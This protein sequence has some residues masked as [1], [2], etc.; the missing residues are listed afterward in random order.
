[1]KKRLLW[2]NEC[3]KRTLQKRVVLREPVDI[4]PSG[5]PAPPKKEEVEEEETL[6]TEYRCPVCGNE[7]TLGDIY[8]TD[9]I[10]SKLVLA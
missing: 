1:M 10:Q 2:C 3:K 4:Y 9:P 7:E 5:Y 8:A 6:K